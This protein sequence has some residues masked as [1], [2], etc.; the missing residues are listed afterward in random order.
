ML[1]ALHSWGL[2]PTVLHALTAFSTCCIVAHVVGQTLD[3]WQA[4]GIAAGAV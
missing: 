3:W 2:T 1:P 4:G